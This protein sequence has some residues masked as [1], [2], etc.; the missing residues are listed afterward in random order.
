MT[1]HRV[2]IPPRGIG[3]AV[4]GAGVTLGMLTVTGAPASA[5]GSKATTHVPAAGAPV[6]C[7]S[8]G[9][10]TGLSGYL[11]QRE[12]T[13]LDRLGR[14]HVLFTIAAHRVVL[15]GK[16]GARYRLIGAG[17]DAVLYRT[18]NVAGAIE[19]EDEA[20]TFNVVGRH[21]VVGVVRFRLHVRANQ[22]PQVHDAST[23]QLPNMS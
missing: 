18:S 9:T 6:T 14:A 15:T 11:S 10:L 23:C 3:L 2:P 4:A 8:V 5:A 17:Y 20:F 19:R 1:T 12:S 22:T 7:Q 13:R 16:N 21:A